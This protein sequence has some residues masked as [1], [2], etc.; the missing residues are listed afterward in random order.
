MTTKRM[1]SVVLL[2]LALACLWAPTAQAQHITVDDAA[3][4]TIDP[5]LDFTSV[6]F[7]NRDRAVVVAF[8][9]ARDRRGEVIFPVRVRGRGTVALVVSQHPRSGEDHLIFQTRRSDHA[10]CRGLRSTWDRPAARLAIRLPSRC[11][12]HGNYGAIKS[13]ALTEGF[14]SASSDVDYAPQTPDGHIRWTGWLP[15][16]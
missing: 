15:R 6:H 14:H 4:D 11:V 12:L 9:F 16:G 7:S 13:W 8:T 3:G 10:T 5:G 1:S 2:T